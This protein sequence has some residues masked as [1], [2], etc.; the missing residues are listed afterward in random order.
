MATKINAMYDQARTD[1]LVLSGSIL[2]PLSIGLEDVVVAMMDN[3]FT[4]NPSHTDITMFAGGATLNPADDAYILKNKSQRKGSIIGQVVASG[5]KYIITSNTST[6]QRRILSINDVKFEEYAG[7]QTCGSFVLYNKTNGR[8]LAYI[9]DVLGLPFN[10]ESQKIHLS[11]SKGE[12]RTLAAERVWQNSTWNSNGIVPDPVMIAG[13]SFPFSDPVVP[14]LRMQDQ[15]EIDDQIAI[16][17]KPGAQYIDIAPGSRAHPITGDMTRVFDEGAINS[18]IRNLLFMRPTDMPF[19]PFAGA[20]LDT[21][22]FDLNDTI[23]LNTI[24]DNIRMALN[25]Y[26][27]RIRVKAIKITAPEPDYIHID[28]LYHALAIQKDLSYLVRLKRY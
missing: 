7:L 11:F 21:Y 26:E 20:G 24:R 1:L 28:I 17:G 15:R 16:V 13:S 6:L 18:S 9:G 27:P 10:T 19:N 2:A 12:Y 4:F 25:T 14:P 8:M 23:T 5:A 22:L 3:T